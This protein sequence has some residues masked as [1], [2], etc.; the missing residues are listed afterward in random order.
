[1][2]TRVPRRLLVVALA[3]LGGLTGCN[4]GGG[5]GT[6]SE[7]EA[8]K[9]ELEVTRQKLAESDKQATARKQELDRLVL[10]IETFKK[11]ISDSNVAAIQKDKRIEALQKQLNDRRDAIRF[12]EISASRERGLASIA[13]DQYRQF[14]T[15]YPDSPLVTDANRAINELTAV[16]ERETRDRAAMIDPK[17]RTREVVK[18]FQ[19]GIATVDE[20]TPL[21]RQKSAAEV[22]KLLGPPNRTY[23]NGTEI[24]YVDRIIDT[25][26]GNKDTLVITFEADRVVSLRVGYRGREIKL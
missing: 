22:I 12:F 20:I 15:D 16:V 19:E 26:T 10:E 5:G 13:L 11:Q 21:L 14:I 25:A 23:R 7:I 18:N 9:T 8:L 4:R 1:M 6:A 24:G 17:R 3:L 2:Y